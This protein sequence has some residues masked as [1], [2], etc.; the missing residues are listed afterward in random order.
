M[1]KRFKYKLGEE[2]KIRELRKIS[3]F[4]SFLRGNIKTLAKELN[5]FYQL[6]KNLKMRK[7]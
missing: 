3:G 2:L 7:Y 5:K 6:E 4:F 1:E